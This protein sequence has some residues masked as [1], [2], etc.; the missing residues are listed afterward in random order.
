VLRDGVEAA[1][2]L[3]LARGID[4]GLQVVAS[5]RQIAA[6]MTTLRA[7]ARTMQAEHAPPAPTTKESPVASLAEHVARRRAPAG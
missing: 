7:R 3:E 5:S 4:Q 2:V 1:C 6:L